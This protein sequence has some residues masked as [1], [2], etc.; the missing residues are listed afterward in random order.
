M[1]LS[2]LSDN[3]NSVTF[4]CFHPTRTLCIDLFSHTQP[5]HVLKGRYV[6]IP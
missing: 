5:K 3:L 1:Y 2:F 4:V 6:T